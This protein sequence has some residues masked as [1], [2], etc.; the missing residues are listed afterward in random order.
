MKRITSPFILAVHPYLKFSVSADSKLLYFGIYGRDRS[1]EVF[2]LSID[3][4]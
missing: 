2:N 3:N 1:D 4:F